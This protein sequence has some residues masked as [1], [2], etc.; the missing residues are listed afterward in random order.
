MDDG[1]VIEI[2]AGRHPVVEALQPD[3]PFVPNDAFLDDGDHRVKLVTGPNM[4]GKSTYLRQI[5]LI[6]VLCQ[7]GSFVPAAA[8]K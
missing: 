8:G 4:G 5:A 3:L 7:M 6:A 2:R 1:A